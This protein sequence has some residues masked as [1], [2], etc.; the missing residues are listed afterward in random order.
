M[1][2][3]SPFRF[4]PIFLSYL[5]AVCSMHLF[6]SSLHSKCHEM[7]KKNKKKMKKNAEQS[8]FKLIIS[9]S[10]GFYF[11]LYQICFH[12]ICKVAAIVASDCNIDCTMCVCVSAY[13]IYIVVILIDCCTLFV[14]TF[15]ALS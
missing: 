12:L 14:R 2:T 8:V 5:F 7:E 6:S 3:S 9:L 1:R 4:L 10:F 15:N 13:C 11:N